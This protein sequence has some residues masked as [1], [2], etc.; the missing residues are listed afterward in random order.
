MMEFQNISFGI[1]LLKL[2]RFV[3]SHGQEVE[4]FSA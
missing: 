1:M 2:L 3:S 4:N